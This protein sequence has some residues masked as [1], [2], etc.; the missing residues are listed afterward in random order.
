MDNWF[1][2]GV[3]LCD[4]KLYTF[5]ANLGRLL[6][7]FYFTF[8]AM[9]FKLSSLETDSIKIMIPLHMQYTRKQKNVRQNI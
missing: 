7:P 9:I 8:L 3:T 1:A 2:L 6:A 4:K 5:G